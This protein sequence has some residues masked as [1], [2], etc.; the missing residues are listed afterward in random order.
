MGA[1]TL[2]VLEVVKLLKWQQQHHD[3]AL[4]LVRCREMATCVVSKP[5]PSPDDELIFWGK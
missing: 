3:A 2:R 5:S 1:F 4:F